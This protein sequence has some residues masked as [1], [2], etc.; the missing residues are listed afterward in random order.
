MVVLGLGNDLRGDD[1]IGLE[2]SRRLMARDLD[3]LVVEQ[4]EDAL[5]ILGAFEGAALVVVVDAAQGGAAPGTIHRLEIAERALTRDLGRCS[6]HGLGLAEALALGEALGRLPPRLVVYAI[7]GASF[8][9]GSAFSTAVAT[10]LDEVER[11][12]LAEIGRDPE[13]EDDPCTKPR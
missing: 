3:R 7:E 1:G 8:D 11:R 5:A 13:M 6:S 10:V 2:I 4:P 9:H 12:V